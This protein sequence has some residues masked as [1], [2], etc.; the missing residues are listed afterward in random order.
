MAIKQRRTVVKPVVKIIPGHFT[1]Q[2]RAVE[3]YKYGAHVS[4]IPKRSEMYDERLQ[5]LL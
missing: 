5:R 4:C 3:I 1:M 2:R